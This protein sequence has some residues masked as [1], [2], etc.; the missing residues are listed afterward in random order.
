[1]LIFIGYIVG[2]MVK[3]G[4]FVGGVL[5]IGLGPKVQLGVATCQGFSRIVLKT[6]NLYVKQIWLPKELRIIVPLL[7]S[8]ILGILES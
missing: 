7:F 4:K 2:L 6:Q 5:S 8:V 3:H 1:M